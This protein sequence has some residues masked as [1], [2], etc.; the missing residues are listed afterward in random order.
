[1]SSPSAPSYIQFA[2][3]CEGE[4]INLTAYV[5]FGA[6]GIVSD[7]GHGIQRWNPSTGA[8]PG[9][10]SDAP[11]TAFGSAP[12]GTRGVALV[13]RKAAGV[14]GF[15]FQDTALQRCLGVG[16]TVAMDGATDPASLVS[17]PAAQ[18]NGQLYY[19]NPNTVLAP[20]PATPITVLLTSAGTTLADPTSGSV[21][22]FNFI[23]DGST[24]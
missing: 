10:Y 5:K 24:I 12:S 3:S 17:A 2:Y 19:K 9:T 8:I 14:F 4:R 6:T 1:M 15:D 7:A 23:L 21:V 11:K 20:G 18:L 16:V 22:I 13:T